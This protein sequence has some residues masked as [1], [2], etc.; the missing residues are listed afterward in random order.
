VKGVLDMAEEET[1]NQDVEISAEDKAAIL[2]KD[3]EGNDLPEEAFTDD[4]SGTDLEKE[5]EETTETGE[6][7]ETP[8]EKEETSETKEPSGDEVTKPPEGEKTF[9]QSQLEDIVKERLARKER[10]LEEKYS[11]LKREEPTPSLAREEVP[12]EKQDLGVLFNDPQW[13]GHTLESLEESDPRYFNIAW[14]R[15]GTM[16]QLEK[17]REREKATQETAQWEEESARQIAE[18]RET[19]PEY[20]EDEGKGKGN[21]KFGDLVEWGAEHKIYNLAVAY[22]EKN[23]DAFI[24]KIGKEAVAEH[25][26]NAKKNTGLKR[27]RITEDS[28]ATENDIADMSDEQ[29]EAAFVDSQRTDRAEVRKELVKRGRL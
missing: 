8:P 6:P 5:A 22:R 16:Q 21:D 1:Q 12:L 9:T 28:A 7:E 25:I 14:G 18:F 26:K 11:Q 29:L 4:P 15:I 17:E 10:Q 13:S 3:L 24:E 19:N 23:L 2:G 27:A 20:F